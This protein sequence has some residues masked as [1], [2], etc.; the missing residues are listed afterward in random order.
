MPP[1]KNDIATIGEPATKPIVNP[2]DGVLAQIK[3]LEHKVNALAAFVDGIPTA[4]SYQAVVVSPGGSF[5]VVYKN[6]DVNS[7]G[8]IDFTEAVAAAQEYIKN[9]GLSQA[10]RPS[11]LPI[12]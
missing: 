3:A 8:H 2:L 1:K 11:V 7:D 6:K 5:I 9:H 12:W 4:K 10:H